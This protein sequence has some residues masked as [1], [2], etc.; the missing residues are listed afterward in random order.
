MPRPDDLK[1]LIEHLMAFAGATGSLS[2]TLSPESEAS[3]P[4]TGVEGVRNLVIQNLADKYV[5]AEL[6]RVH[7]NAEGLNRVS[8]MRLRTGDLDGSPLSNEVVRNMAAFACAEAQHSVTDTVLSD[9]ELLAGDF[10][11]ALDANLDVFVAQDRWRVPR[12]GLQLI[13]PRLTLRYVYYVEPAVQ[14]EP[15]EIHVFLMKASVR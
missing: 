8:L 7:A 3:S 2:G 15:E 1:T 11:Y 5:D 10:K 13:A 9:A 12:T 6:G 14:G 4:G